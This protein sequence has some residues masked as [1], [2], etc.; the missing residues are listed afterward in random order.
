MLGANAPIQLPPCFQ[1]RS[2]SA[3]QDRWCGH[4]CLAVCCQAVARVLKSVNVKRLPVS[5]DTCR[6]SSVP[7]QLWSC[8]LPRIDAPLPLPLP[9]PAQVTR[10]RERLSRIEQELATAKQRMTEAETKAAEAEAASAAAARDAMRLSEQ[11]KA[12]KAAADEAVAVAREAEQRALAMSG[13]L[14][15]AR[16]REEQIAGRLQ[17]SEVRGVL[18]RA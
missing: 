9:S 14:A 15:D 12:A 18:V 10:L 6:A 16:R 4:G 13:A 8:R 1:P 5:H 2:A 11:T 7:C 3:S 17:H